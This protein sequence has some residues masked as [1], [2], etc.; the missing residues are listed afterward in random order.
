MDFK[1]SDAALISLSKIKNNLTFFDRFPEASDNVIGSFVERSIR[2][3]SGRT[4][5]DLIRHANKI[6][7][8][9]LKE[10]VKQHSRIDLE[11]REISDEAAEILSKNQG[12][13]VLSGLKKIS[14]NCASILAKHKGELYLL[15]DVEITAQGMETLKKHHGS[16]FFKEYGDFLYGKI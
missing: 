4:V 5:H 8:A 16:F 13:L 12:K 7:S 6:S 1:I 10:I 2:D 15:K 3:S 9:N 14:D 11:L